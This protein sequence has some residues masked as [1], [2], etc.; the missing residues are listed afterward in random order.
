M[1]ETIHGICTQEECSEVIQAISKVLRF[2]LHTQNP[3]NGVSN[4]EHLEDEL[5][6]LQSMINIL[7]REWKLDLS[8][9]EILRKEERHYIMLGQFPLNNHKI[10][11]QYEHFS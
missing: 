2:G 11:E 8:M 6:Q 7:Q 5:S 9:D 10:A 3:L 1:I 4:K